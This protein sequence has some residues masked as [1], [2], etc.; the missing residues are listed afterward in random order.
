MAIINRSATAIAY[1]MFAGRE[2]KI[3]N[4]AGAEGGVPSI[5]HSQM[6]KKRVAV[7]VVYITEAG[8]Q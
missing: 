7:A 3:V 2:K 1:R 4:K 6:A 8:I 5:E